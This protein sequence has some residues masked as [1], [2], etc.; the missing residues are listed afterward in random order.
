MPSVNKVILIGNLTK[1]PDIRYA[2]DGSSVANM[3]LATNETWKDKSGAKQERAEFHRV[4]CF[5]KLS[6]IVADFLRKGALVYIEGR[7]QTRKW[8]DKNGQD[9]YTTEIIASE[10]QMLDS[11]GGGSS[12][13]GDFEPPP[14]PRAGGRSSETNQQEASSPK[15]GGM[16]E[17]DD[18][19]PF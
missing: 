17:F 18:D 8:Q 6:D 7:L 5:P 9:R 19:V 10:M 3:S 11:R 16:P 13:A 14:P 4:A 1:D 15:S 12:N 2:S